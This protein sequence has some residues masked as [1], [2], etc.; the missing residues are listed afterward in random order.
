MHK[1]ILYP[2]LTAKPDM[3][4]S[5]LGYRHIRE[6]LQKH[7]PKGSALNPGN[8]TQAL[9]SVASLQL[10]KSIQPIIM[11]Y[12]ESNLKLHIVDRGFIIWLNVQNRNELL[13]AIGLPGTEANA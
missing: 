4:M 9:Q 13:S 1:W 8:L 12:D 6:I 5:G 2:V 3:L 7:H 11:D 10:S